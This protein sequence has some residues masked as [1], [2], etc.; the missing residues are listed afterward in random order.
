MDRKDR[1]VISTYDNAI[2]RLD[3]EWPLLCADPSA[4]ATVTGWLTDAGVFA[5]GE[6]PGELAAV[7]PELE[8]RDRTRGREHSDRWLGAVLRHVADPG[9]P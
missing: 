7:L 6:L 3:A 9:K 2:D 4:C 8:R 1:A 5:P